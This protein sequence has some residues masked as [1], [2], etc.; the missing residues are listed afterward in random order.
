MD[1]IVIIKK[2]CS[3]L[4]YIKECYFYLAIIEY[5]PTQNEIQFPK[6]REGKLIMFWIKSV[7]CCEAPVGA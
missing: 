1:I 5:A 7:I 2:D 3:N 6:R 4:L